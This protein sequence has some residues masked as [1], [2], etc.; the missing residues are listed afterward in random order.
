MLLSLMFSYP[1]YAN[2]FQSEEVRQ[3][4]AV[5][6]EGAANHERRIFDALSSSEYLD[7]TEIELVDVESRFNYTD[8][9]IDEENE[10]LVT[11]DVVISYLYRDKEITL[12]SAYQVAMDENETVSNVDIAEQAVVDFIVRV[13]VN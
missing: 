4:D 6:R 1:L 8:T 2:G 11:C 3:L 7:W 9:S 12:N 10:E 5:C 13:M